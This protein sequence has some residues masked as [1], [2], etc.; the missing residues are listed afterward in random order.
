MILNTSTLNLAMCLVRAYKLLSEYRMPAPLG[1]GF[2]GTFRASKITKKFQP[3][4]QFCPLATYPGSASKFISS[5]SLDALQV[6]LNCLLQA[7]EKRSVFAAGK[8][9][10]VLRSATPLRKTHIS[11]QLQVHRQNSAERVQKVHRSSSCQDSPAESGGRHIFK[12]L[13]CYV[14]VLSTFSYGCCEV[15]RFKKHFMC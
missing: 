8:L 9:H 5:I 1:S 14:F 15:F 13:V 4:S 7:A 11:S 3:K 2:F 6:H 12:V 10:K